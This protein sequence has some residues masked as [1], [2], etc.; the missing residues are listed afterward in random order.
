MVKLSRMLEFVYNKIRNAAR[1]IDMKISRWKYGYIEKLPS[2]IKYFNGGLYDA[3][4]E[5]SCKHGHNTALEYGNLQITYKELVKKINKV[6]RG[7]KALGVEKGDRVTICMP[8]TPEAVYMFYAVNEVGAVASM[9]HPLSSEKEF[10]NFLNQSQSK[11]VLAID[12]AYPRIEAILKNTDV[13][14]L[15]V[16]SA[17][18][19]ME[20]IVKVIYKLTKGRKNHI[21]KTQITMPWGRFLAKADKFIGNPHERVDSDD[22]AVILYSGGTT[23][24]PKGVMLSNLNFNAQ[25]LEA[26]YYA[27]E[28]LKSQHAF[29][30][31]LPNFHAFGLGICTHIPLYWGMRVV[32]IP[33]F[34]AK[35]L[36]MY[37]RKYK[38]NVLCGV[39]TLYEYLTKIKFGKNELKC[40]K[41]VISGGDSM[42]LPL[43]R[44]VNK[45]L[46][47]HGCKLDVQVGYGLTEASG[48]VAFSPVGITDAADVIG[49]AF[50]DCEFLICDLKT[51]KEAA[52]GDDGEILI[53][54]PT[55]ML[56]YLN[57]EEET[58]NS[59][60]TINGK[61]YLKTGD[62]G[63]FDNKGLLHFKA[64]LK[65]M[66]ITNGYNVYPSHV[67]DVVL[68]CSAVEKC[69]V[70]GVPDKV[71]G[72]TV[73]VFIVYK[74]GRGNSRADKNELQK[75]LKTNLAKYEMP[76]IFRT[77]E[78]LPL[79]K[80]NKVDYKA[81][82][83]LD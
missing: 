67:E 78:S 35:K 51:G 39:P 58:N 59:F 13:Q 28:L 43:K 72:E 22:L 41:G 74:Q 30:T 63:F 7:L 44:R 29:L 48:V 25:A 49:Y 76:R 53:H 42:S 12:V 57:N 83:Q 68:K 31:F 75:I 46:H 16:V 33:Q 77:I 2:D 21:K 18:R 14:H 71:H 1:K 73:K 47:E 79:T 64:R 10:E 54:S 82:E 37:V 24:T 62:I 26:K 9:V 19:S 17:T 66:I 5:A 8:N 69:A 56:G 20:F 4:Y 60:V 6:A 23:G 27:P 38:F 32:L 45:Y 61:R 50:P 55:V 36:K 11:V 40:L 3:V 81:L 70:I 80:M 15:I 65:R 52:V 34:S